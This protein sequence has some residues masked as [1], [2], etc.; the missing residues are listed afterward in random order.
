MKSIKPIVAIV[1][2]LA[3]LFSTSD[4]SFASNKGEKEITKV[5]YF[6]KIRRCPTCMAIEKQTRKVLKEQAYAAAKENEELEFKSMNSENSTNKK[7]VKEFGV[8]GSALFILKG[9]EKID[10]TNQAFLYA[11]TQP[12]KFKMILREALD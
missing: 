9:E 3:C 1:F 11:R 8:S 5:Y 2:V 6:H 7:L 10:L 12:E 4:K